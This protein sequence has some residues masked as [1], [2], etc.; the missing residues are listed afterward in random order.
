MS[1]DSENLNTHY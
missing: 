1:S